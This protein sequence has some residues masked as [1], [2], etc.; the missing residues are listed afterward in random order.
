M[1]L[2]SLTELTDDKLATLIAAAQAEQQARHDRRTA[3]L[4]D[5]FRT[6]AEALGLEP[7]KLVAAFSK[8]GVGRPRASIAGDGRSAVKPKYRNPRTSETWAG[9]GQKPEWVKAHLAKGGKLEELL[10]PEVAA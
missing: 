3:E 8:R 6:R 5:D 4:L 7:A 9:R 10:I 1:N 2:T